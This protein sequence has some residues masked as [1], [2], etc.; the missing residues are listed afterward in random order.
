MASGFVFLW[1]SWMCELVGLYVYKCSLCLLWMFFLLFVSFFLF[2]WICFILSFVLYYSRVYLLYYI[3]LLFPSDRQKGMNPDERWGEEE[4]EGEERGEI[5][6]C[7][8]TYM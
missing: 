1:Y 7:V 6:T 3:T 5:M 2:Q 8:Y 4:L